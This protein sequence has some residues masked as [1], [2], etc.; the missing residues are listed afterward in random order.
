MHLFRF[1]C[2]SLLLL[3]LA[4]CA[5]LSREDCLQ[6]NYHLLGLQDGQRGLLPERVENDAQSCREFGVNIDKQAYQEGYALGLETY[7]NAANAI[8]LG[9][10]GEDYLPVC[11]PEKESDFFNHY[12]Q[13]LKS[14]CNADY[15]F[16]SGKRGSLKDKNCQLGS[17]RP[18]DDGY[19]RGYT[20]YKIYARK[21]AIKE[22][23]H[24]L[25]EELSRLPKNAADYA[26]QS[27]AL[28]REQ[29]FLQQEYKELIS[30]EVKLSFPDKY[31]A[32]N[33]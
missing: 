10:D 21:E 28:L 22:S 17:F 5:S 24:G 27:S 31:S 15:G 3:S 6:T 11:P 4:G 13:G 33:N 8:K 9:R 18:Y 30:R 7:C 12:L 2:L 1:T 32:A 29:D 19:Q 16:S 25:D 23:L 14:F 26:Q 20:L